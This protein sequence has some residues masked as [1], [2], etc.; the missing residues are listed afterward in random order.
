MNN[1]SDKPVSEPE[2]GRHITKIGLAVLK[3]CKILLVRKRYS[4][5][6]ILPGG[7]PEGDETHRQTLVREITE[8]LGCKTDRGWL[9]YIGSF[10]DIAADTENTRV[11]VHLYL[12]SLI[13]EPVPCSEIEELKWVDPSDFRDTPVASSLSNS[14]LPFLVGVVKG[15]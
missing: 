1:L 8:E 10:S 6:F 12:G 13:G 15:Q 7:K 4:A 3:N 9:E 2:V 5:V 14:I 11:T